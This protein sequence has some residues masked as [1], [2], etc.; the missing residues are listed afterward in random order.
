MDSRFYTKSEL[1]SILKN[2]KSVDYS[3]DIWNKILLLD[4]SKIFRLNFGKNKKLASKKDVA[5]FLGRFQP[6]H[7][8]HIYMLNKILKV[9]KKIKMGKEL[10]K[11]PK[12]TI[13]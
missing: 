12:E 4:L 5:L 10:K 9:Y 6:L 1:T 8:G 2:E 3:K 13:S 7:H 11:I